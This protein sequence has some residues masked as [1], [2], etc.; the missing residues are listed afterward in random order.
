M[1][2]HKPYV[3][4]G[5]ALIAAGVIGLIVLAFLSGC[6]AQTTITPAKTEATRTT[7]DDRG[8]TVYEVIVTPG[9]AK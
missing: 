1:R 6:Q 9:A 4:G 8:R 7:R 2:S 3:V 5:A